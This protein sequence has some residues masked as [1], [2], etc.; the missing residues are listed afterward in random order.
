MLCQ[1]KL[2]FSS[3]PPPG[4]SGESAFGWYMCLLCSV[5]NKVGKASDGV[6]RHYCGRDHVN[7]WRAEH[8][9]EQRSTKEL[10]DLCGRTWGS[11]RVTQTTQDK[12]AKVKVQAKA[13]REQIVAAA[14]AAVE[15][16]PPPVPP[17]GGASCTPT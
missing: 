10:T 11:L 15:T 12:E 8:P 4:K 2:T 3:K 17:K 1:E 9:G 6:L 16:P 7:K 13:Q 5:T 14:R